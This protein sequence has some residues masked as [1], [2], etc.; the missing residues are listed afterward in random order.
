M[1][2]KGEAC[3]LQCK[4]LVY[5]DRGSPFKKKKS[6]SYSIG[7][8]YSYPSVNVWCSMPRSQEK[9]KKKD[10]SYNLPDT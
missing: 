7:Q 2:L 1:V 8:L 10:I 4:I 9:K 6:E 5:L 3:F